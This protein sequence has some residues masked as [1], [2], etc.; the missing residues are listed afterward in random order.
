M[1]LDLTGPLRED[2]YRILSGLVNPAHYRPIG[3]MQGPNWYCRTSDQFELK[4][5]K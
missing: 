5:P 1:E 4:R 3:R 2:A